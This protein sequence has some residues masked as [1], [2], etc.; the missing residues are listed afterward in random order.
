MGIL[1]KFTNYA[2][3]IYHSAGDVQ[4]IADKYDQTMDIADQLYHMIW[5]CWNKFAK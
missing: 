2:S 4:G 1:S 5:K 3:N